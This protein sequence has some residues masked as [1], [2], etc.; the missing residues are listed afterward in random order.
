MVGSRVTN[1]GKSR[2]KSGEMLEILTLYRR[3]LGMHGL[4]LKI[5]A[6]VGR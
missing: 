1:Y 6:N 5:I 2:F 3:L 4:E